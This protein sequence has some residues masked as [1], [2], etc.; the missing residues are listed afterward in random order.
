M[1]SVFVKERRPYTKEELFRIFSDKKAEK[2][3]RK[4]KEYGI[5]K[6]IKNN[7]DKDLSDLEDLEII[8]DESDTEFDYFYVFTF[9]GIIIVDE[10][11]L[12]CYPKYI[13][14]NEEPLEELKQVV[15]VLE[16]VNSKEQIVK[17]Y[18]NNQRDNQFNRLAAIV[19]LIN[20][21]YENG[22]YTNIK[23][24]IETNGSGEINWNRTIN[25]TF[26]ILSNSRPYYTELQ[27]LKHQNDD[28]DYFKRLH[29]CII[30]ICSK[31]LAEASL[32]ELFGFEELNLTEET[33]DDFGEKDYILYQL[34]KEMS[35]QFNTRKLD[36][37]KVM[38]MFIADQGT[39][40]D[41]STF[42]LYGTNSYHVV[43]ETVCKDIFEDKLNTKL[44]ALGLPIPLNE[45]Y[46]SNKNN[47]LIEII[48]KPIWVDSE[49]NEHRPNKTLIPDLISIKD[50]LFVIMDAKYYNI[51]L[52]S[53]KDISG[54][55]GISDV[56]KQYL[57]QLAYREFISLH[58]FRRIKNCFLMP[59]EQNTIVKKG[60]A[61]MKML[62]S[63]N[64]SNIQV[65]LLPA[66][67]VYELYLTGKKMDL[68]DLELNEP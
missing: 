34:E 53:G 45:K 61:K 67:I 43:W 64:L 37:L 63:L 20:D 49:G 54:N 36:L 55:P 12:K 9:V 47:T 48:E 3:I 11:V 65:R 38:H 51:V 2:C 66:R 41:N 32:D 22:I 27:T 35:V 1:T 58:D 59:T 42:S 46:Q 25:E 52:E 6:T 56:T 39:L 29:E 50:D 24:I 44:K 68:L 4:L 26:A 18:V 17:M 5:L 7:E 31:E 28:Y 60:T 23:D 21:Y 16:K 33:I 14:S 57:Y 19:Y 8:V 13:F 40:L 10:C 15:R 30:T 62:E